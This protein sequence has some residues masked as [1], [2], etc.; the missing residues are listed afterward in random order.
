MATTAR[1]RAK[2]RARTAT[3]ARRKARVSAKAQAMENL[4]KSATCAERRVISH[5]TVGHDPITTRW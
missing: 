3:E 5:E 1:A 4:T 2:E